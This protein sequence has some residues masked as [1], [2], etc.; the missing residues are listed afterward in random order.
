[1]RV[2]INISNELMKRLEPLKPELN[3]SQVCRDALTAKVEQ[4][5]RMK[6][7]LDDAETKAVVEGLWDREKELLSA[8]VFDWEMLGYQDAAAWVKAASLE[9]WDDLLVELADCREHNWPEW[10]IV[11]PNIDGVDW[12]TDH[13][14]ELHNRTKELRQQ[15]YDLYRRHLRSGKLNV[16][17]QANKKEYMTAWISH[18]KAVWE[19][20]T[21]RELEYLEGQ[22][23]QRSAPPEPEVPEHLFGDGQSSEEQPFRVVPHHPGYAPGVYPL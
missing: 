19:L 3:I 23:A 20:V 13:Q 2:G 22:L 8:I 14:H 1:M 15:E 21:L 6:A 11:P 12:L 18:V 17:Y 16:D 10:E 5:E 7:G 4:Y 9:N